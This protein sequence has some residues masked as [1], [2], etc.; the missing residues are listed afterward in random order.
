[1]R[2]TRQMNDLDRCCPDDRPEGRVGRSD[3]F[4]DRQSHAS[5]A[6]RRGK[7]G[8]SEVR[9]IDHSVDMPQFDGLGD[10][11][12]FLQ[13]FHTLAQYYEWRE[14]EKLF[15]MKQCIRGDAQYM[16]MDMTSINQSDEFVNI[17]RQRFGASPHAERFRAE[18]LQLRRGKLTLEQLHMKVRT[19]VSK[20]APGSWTSLTEIYARDAF[21]TALDN[22]E[23]RRRIKLTCPPPTTLAAA[24]D[25]AL[26]ATAIDIGMGDVYD[27]QNNRSPQPHRARQARALVGGSCGPAEAP[28]QQ[29]KDLAEEH[30][31]LKEQL[32]GIS[33][34]MAKLSAAGTKPASS[35]SRADV[36]P[37]AEVIPRHRNNDLC[38]R[39]GNKG[40]WARH[41]PN[42]GRSTTGAAR[43]NTLSKHKSE[44]VNVYIH[45]VYRGRKHLVL[46]DTGCEVSVLSTKI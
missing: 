42:I 14:E 25:L 1:M 20:A 15:R 7:E 30:R 34:E 6:V 32:D 33:A 46:V 35:Q 37:H 36:I 8:Y 13:R 11:E 26:R 44:K 9:R 45:A 40:H 27:H 10:V 24:Y 5:T 21:L 39:C 22:N 38:H 23:L 28:S 19:L 3:L 29:M 4:E 16:L 41:C 31:K 12:L 2:L 18:L 17:L 43:A